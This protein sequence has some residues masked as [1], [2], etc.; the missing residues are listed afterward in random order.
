MGVDY[1]TT[2]GIA[3]PYKQGVQVSYFDAA[4]NR[5]VYTPRG[6]VLRMASEVLSG[7]KVVTPGTYL[8]RA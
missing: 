3:A 5:N 8:D 7:T 4:A 6:D 1:A 2:W